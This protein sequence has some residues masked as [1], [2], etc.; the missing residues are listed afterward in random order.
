MLIILRFK[1]ILLLTVV[2]MASAVFAGAQEPA[3]DETA[4]PTPTP[5]LTENEVKGV[6]IVESVI[7]VYSNLRGRQGL[8]QIRKTGLEIGTI[9]LRNDAGTVT[10]GEYEQRT[11]RGDS[12]KA[13]KVRMDQSFPNA[14]FALIY[15]G[16]TVFG[17]FNNE[18]FTP[19]ADAS[20][21]FSNRLWYS[22]EALLGYYETESKVAFERDDT[23][24]GVDY[25]VIKLTD[26]EERETFFYVSK[27]SF[28]VMMIEY[29]I[30]GVKYL[31]KYYDYNYAQNTL[32][33][34]KTI[35]WADGKIVEE[36]EIKT[37]TFG[38]EI[39]EQYFSLS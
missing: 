12:L 27:K 37:V 29:E 24:M 8:N 33:P 39:G 14:R 19:N 38:Q 18:K 3:A 28:R 11:V 30:N 23:V 22:L 32:F 4:K 25:T 6:Q 34:Y 31:R 13:T 2:L 7:L 1:T 5:Q 10:K 17:V 21:R 35:L 16:S 9:Q 26:K 20:Q 15:D 36:Q